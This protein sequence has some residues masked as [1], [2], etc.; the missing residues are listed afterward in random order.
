V[1]GVTVYDTRFHTKKFPDGISYQYNGMG[2]LDEASQR[3]VNDESRL[4]AYE[5]TKK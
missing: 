5:A 1:F 4:A 3:F 2:T